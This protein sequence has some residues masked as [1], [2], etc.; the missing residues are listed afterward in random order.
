[1]FES[2]ILNRGM[3]LG[4][5]YGV[6]G[7]GMFTDKNVETPF[8]DESADVGGAVYIV[9]TIAGVIICL[10]ITTIVVGSMSKV[11]YSANATGGNQTGLGLPAA[12]NTTVAGLDTNANSGFTLAGILPIAVVGVGILTIIIG[13]FA[14]R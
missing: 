7:L 1:M 3:A 11:I 12:W 14:F 5:K 9:V 13:A 2:E 4:A 6:R 8:I 10:Y